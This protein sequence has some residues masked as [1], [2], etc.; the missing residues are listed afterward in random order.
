MLPNPGMWYGDWRSELEYLLGTRP[1]GYI[2]PSVVDN[3]DFGVGGVHETLN[4]LDAGANGANGVSRDTATSF[5][6][7][8]CGASAPIVG[9]GSPDLVDGEDGIRSGE[10][11]LK[12][13]RI[14]LYRGVHYRVWSD[15]E[16]SSEGED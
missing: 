9:V 4:V 16:D 7:I 11:P 15:I 12:R 5:A 8:A 1:E 13:P 3:G 2:D 6:G 14:G 10:P